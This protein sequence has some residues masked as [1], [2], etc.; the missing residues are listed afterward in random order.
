MS[1]SLTITLSNSAAAVVALETRGN[2]VVYSRYISDHGVTLDTVSDHV[3]AL[4]DL[5]ISS[6]V[7]DGD[8]KVAV[9]GFKNRVR[10][11]LNSN[12][13]KVSPSKVEPTAL[14]TTLGAK[15]TLAEVTA[16]WKA[17]QK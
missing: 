15:A 16:A 7:L 13:G 10:N 9:K 12:L 14:I 2:K 5:A 8:D 1:K 11:G 4:A 6:K 3:A 17:A